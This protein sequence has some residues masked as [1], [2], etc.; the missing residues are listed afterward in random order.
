MERAVAKLHATFDTFAAADAKGFVDGVFVVR[1]FQSRAPDGTGGTKLVFRAGVQGDGFGFKKGGA[2]FAVTAH[3]IELDALD[4][5]FFQHAMRG[6]IA[7]L[8]ALVGVEL[9]ERFF[10]LTSPY[11]RRRRRAEQEQERAANA[12]S[13]KLTSCGWGFGHNQEIFFRI[14]RAGGN[15]QS[16]KRAQFSQRP[17]LT[18]IRPFCLDESL[19]PVTKMPPKRRKRAAPRK[20]SRR[21]CFV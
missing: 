15:W 8:G 14:A 7:A 12:A 9:P 6:A 21:F 10:M 19:Y 4:S 13:E 3:F 2:E 17:C 11:H 20:N 16:W 5:R 1:V 18:H